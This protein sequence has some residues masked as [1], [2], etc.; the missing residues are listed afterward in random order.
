[1]N[2]MNILVSKVF[3][4][5]P[6]NIRAYNLALIY[7]KLLYIVMHKNGIYSYRNVV[8][9]ETTHEL[10]LRLSFKSYN[11]IYTDV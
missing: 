3:T 6:M 4:N 2:Y 5:Q 8:V 7:R 10:E 11:H 9:L 1:M